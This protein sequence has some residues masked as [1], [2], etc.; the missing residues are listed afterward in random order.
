MSGRRSYDRAVCRWWLML[1]LLGACLLNAVALAA[2]NSAPLPKP[3][4]ETVNPADSAEMVWVPA[5]EFLMG[6]SDDDLDAI[7]HR[8]QDIKRKDF[9]DQQP[10]HVVR[11][12]GFWIYKYDVTV[13][14][15][16]KFCA[17]TGREMPE[18]PPWSKENLPVVNV[19]WY[20]ATAYAKW[21][22]A[23]L[24]TEAEW[25]KAAR[26]TDG[27]IFPWGDQWD[28][29]KCNNNNCH[30]PLRG[31]LHG[32]RATPGG[33]FPA[34]ASPYGVQDMAG[35]VWQWCADWYAPEYYA[36]APAS[37]P[38]GPATGEERVQRGGSWGSSSVTIMCAGRNHE[39]PDLTF[40]DD[41]GFRCA[42][43]GK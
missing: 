15:Y 38:G 36:H 42:M 27:R 4:K 22:G 28:A 9:A 24:P 12:D 17:K 18:Q 30:S 16:R 23:R 6:C 34:S 3:V 11:L 37:N 14:Q 7:C 35:N 8:R 5:G 41:G 25:E 39:A 32:Y 21:A 29:E 13:A 40:H 2:G 31:G 33:S 1:P 43:S 10:Q 26:G 20:D 19:S